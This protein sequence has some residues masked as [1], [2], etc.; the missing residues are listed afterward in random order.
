MRR[1]I[2]AFVT[3]AA[4]TATAAITTAAATTTTPAATVA[5]APVPAAV[6]RQTSLPRLTASPL[7]PLTGGRRQLP[8]VR[9]RG[10]EAGAA[11]VGGAARRECNP[12]RMAARGEEK[13]GAPPPTGGES[14]P[15]SDRASGAATARHADGGG[16]PAAPAPT[17]AVGVGKAPP[18]AVASTIPPPPP[19]LPPGL[20]I[21]A[22]RLRCALR[23][24]ALSDILA[25][26]APAAGLVPDTAMPGYHPAADFG[27]RQAVVSRAATAAGMAAFL[28]AVGIGGG[29]GGVRYSG[30]SSCGDGGGRGVPG[31]VVW[32]ADPVAPSTSV[33][34]VS[35]GSGSDHNNG[36]GHE[37]WQVPP[38]SPEVLCAADA[39][40]RA[41]L[42]S[43]CT[44]AVVGGTLT[45]GGVAT[46]LG[47]IVAVR[48]RLLASAFP[49]W[50]A[51]GRPNGE[52]EGTGE[53]R[54][55]GVDASGRAVASAAAQTQ[56]KVPADPAT[57]S[58]LGDGVAPDVAVDDGGATPGTG[59]D[60]ETIAVDVTNSA[61]S[62]GVAAADASASDDVTEADGAPARYG[63]STADA[64]FPAP[65]S[66][67]KDA[68]VLVMVRRG[69]DLSASAAGVLS[70]APPLAFGEAWLAAVLLGAAARGGRAD[71]VAAAAAAAAALTNSG[72]ASAD[73]SVAPPARL[74]VVGVQRQ[75]R[76]RRRRRRGAAQG[77]AR[78]RGRPPVLEP[79]WVPPPSVAA[80]TSDGD[81]RAD[82]AAANDDDDDAA[83]AAAA[84]A[85]AAPAPPAWALVEL[86]WASR[87]GQEV[88]AA[89][90]DALSWARAVS[91]PEGVAAVLAG[92][93]PPA[94]AGGA[95]L[96]PPPLPTTVDGLAAAV[97]AAAA[98]GASWATPAPVDPHTHAPWAGARR[99]IAAASRDVGALTLLPPAAVA[100]ARAR[101]LSLGDSS[102]TAIALG[103][104]PNSRAGV[105]LRLVSSLYRD[106]GGQGWEGECYAVT[107]RGI[108][109]NHGNW[110]LLPAGVDE[111]S[112]PLP[113][114]LSRS[115]P[116]PPGRP[117]PPRVERD[118][119]EMAVTFF[120]DLELAPSTDTDDSLIFMVGARRR[121]VA[122]PGAP[123]GVSASRVDDVTLTAHTLCLAGEADLL[124]RW[125]GWMGDMLAESPVTATAAVA[126]VEAAGT[127]GEGGA[128]VMAAAQANLE[129]GPTNPTL[130]PLRLVAY[131]PEATLLARAAER[132]PWL[133]AA[134]ASLSPPPICRRP[135]SRQARAN[136]TLASVDGAAADG[137]CGVDGADSGGAKGPNGAAVMAGATSP[138]AP[139]PPALPPVLDVAALM[140]EAGVQV[141]SLT[142]RLGDVAAAIRRDG[143]VTW[144]IPGDAAVELVENTSTA[145]HASP[146]II[147]DGLS[148]MATALSAA[149][150]VAAGDAE[151]LADAPAM[152]AVASYNAADVRDVEVV[153]RFLW[154]RL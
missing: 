132:H 16:P 4:T 82:A 67:D 37:W 55:K 5:T 38:P 17:V 143:L 45:G 18:A 111:R 93:P 21:Y 61:A 128:A 11:G 59:V 57:D 90:A 28:D 43:V 118:V 83:A 74:A 65:P 87:P 54:R 30:G 32:L 115:S 91:T 149:E 103:V 81:V 121:L 124:R 2:T 140:H 122:A 36:G 106:G 12:F 78:R 142:R 70:A 20:L 141:R 72:S 151:R 77:G 13:G 9:W 150:A 39:A 33:G 100:A 40:T 119:S 19:R 1:P 25:V 95:P 75:R 26:A 94:T 110:R 69:R 50:A 22:P 86:P 51:L 102:T 84:D 41:A 73:G 114:L 147:P 24:E 52:G 137:G 62:V 10:L 27:R 131:G 53:K 56:G 15:S 104:D 76:R 34:G 144:D 49:H 105:A 85:L 60:N 6:S 109:H 42:A 88:A 112:P 146:V 126:S 7:V 117:P 66:P 125:V 8:L 136:G 68:W 154:Q 92:T 97:A 148:A 44:D 63:G 64:G 134:L 35:G 80:A 23:G 96:P 98:R 47:G 129:A 145:V 46:R 127:G 133:P 31:K 138:T 123:G 58:H 152:V 3:T 29:G 107:K 139:L 135:S 99:A 120:F 79:L 130:P 14:K 101:G 113:P 89:T 116:P 48:E 108:P 71:S 153:H